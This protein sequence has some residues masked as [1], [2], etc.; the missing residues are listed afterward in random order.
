M[1]MD[2]SQISRLESGHT[3]NVPLEVVQHLAH[4]LGVTVA[5]LFGEEAR[6]AQAEY[7]DAHPAAAI[8]ADDRAPQGLRDLAADRAL[9]ELLRIT[10]DEWRA[11][12]SLDLP[13]PPGKDGYV[14]LLLTIRAV[15]ARPV[16]LI[17]SPAGPK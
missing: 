8:L 10:A 9:A 14:Q 16:H 5:Y 3:K 12:R 6:Q 17:S 1:G 7:G 15:T 13:T 2:K 4:E 11:L